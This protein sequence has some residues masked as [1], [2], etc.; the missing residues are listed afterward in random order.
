MDYIQIGRFSF[1]V[2]MLK[3]NKLTD[4]YDKFPNISKETV[5]LAWEKVNPKKT[6]AKN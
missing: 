4:S 2:E 1:R 3:E 6:K 5:K